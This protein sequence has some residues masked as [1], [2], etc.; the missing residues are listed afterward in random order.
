MKTNYVQI[1][2]GNAI[3]KI[4]IQIPA[5]NQWGF[6]LCDEYDNWPGGLMGGQTTW[7]VI[8]EADVPQ[9]DIDR[10]AQILS[11]SAQTYE[12]YPIS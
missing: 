8:A 2:S 6:D 3:G 7:Q 5:A 4:L 9:A 12:L 11:W 1:T 10:L